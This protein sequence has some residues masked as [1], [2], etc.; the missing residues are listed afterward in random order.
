MRFYYDSILLTE[1]NNPSILLIPDNNGQLPL[2]NI[3]VNNSINEAGCTT[4]IMEKLIKLF[5]DSINS[6]NINDETPLIIASALGHNGA[7]EILLKNDADIN[8]K[9]KNGF[10]PL[11]IAI[12]FKHDNL[13]NLLIE[14]SNYIDITNNAGETPLRIAVYF[15][16]NDTAKLLCDKGANPNIPDQDGMSPLHLAESSNNNELVSFFLERQRQPLAQVHHQ[17]QLQNL[18]QEYYQQPLVTAQYHQDPRHQQHL[19]QSGRPPLPPRG[20]Q[21]TSAPGYYDRPLAQGQQNYEV[22]QAHNPQHLNQEYYQAQA[23]NSNQGYYQQTLAQGQQNYA[24]Y[25]GYT[26]LSNNL[27]ALQE[28][29]MHRNPLT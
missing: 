12:H 4:H 11:H 8:C 28:E 5:P 25:Q 26:V 9:D 3:T 22:Q 19:N 13:A 2:H 20:N 10:T 21:Q 27:L 16:L 18:N 15:G 24:G 6:T 23:Q 1:P 7:A 17:E 29:I 14:R